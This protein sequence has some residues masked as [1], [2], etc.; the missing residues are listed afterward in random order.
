MEHIT[1][2]L[3]TILLTLFRKGTSDS[4]P[5][6]IKNVS[7]STTLPTMS[8]KIPWFHN[9]ESTSEVPTIIQSTLNHLLI[10]ES[11]HKFPQNVS[12]GTSK[13]SDVSHSSEVNQQHN[14]SSS[15]TTLTS[16]SSIASIP[17]SLPELISSKLTSAPT[18]TSISR[19]HSPPGLKSNRNPKS[20][21]P[22]GIPP[23]TTPLGATTCH[24]GVLSCTLV[25]VLV[26]VGVVIIIMVII[27]SVVVKICRQVKPGDGPH[28][29][30]EDTSQSITSFDN[31]GFRWSDLDIDAM[32]ANKR[33]S[34]IDV[35]L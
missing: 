5:M 16:V 17:E 12:I 25:Y 14:T 22:T 6:F 3:C 28:I 20:L 8:E 29:I 26:S 21:F 23:Y 13:T 11:K 33:E 30:K 15:F 7:K 10:K 19:N 32:Q 24:I 9:T 1:I 34:V 27:I 35:T 4:L 31:P 2:T 18:T